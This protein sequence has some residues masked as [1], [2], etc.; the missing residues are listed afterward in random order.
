L[1][2]AARSENAIR[3]W[4]R[5]PLP[6]Q[7]A[8]STYGVTVRF[9]NSTASNGARVGGTGIRSAATFTTTSR[10]RPSSAGSMSTTRT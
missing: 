10:D 5:L 4:H 6:W 1:I 9:S 7:R 2:P 3:A 8:L